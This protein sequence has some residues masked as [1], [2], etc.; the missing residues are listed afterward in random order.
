[1]SEKIPSNSGRRT[2]RLAWI[3]IGI[4]IL[5]IRMGFAAKFPPDM[6]WSDAAIYDSIAL[7]LLAGNGYSTDG[8]QPSRDRPPAYPFF[9]TLIY[10]VIGRN[11]YVVVFL[12]SLLA[13]LTAYLSA[14]L[15]EHVFDERAGWL[16]AL[17]VATYPALIYYDTRTLREGPTAFFV[18]LTVYLA[19]RAAAG[20]RRA[21]FFCGVCIAVSSMNRPETL[22]LI[23][24]ACLISLW[25]R[26]RQEILKLICLVLIPIFACWVPW[27]IRNKVTFGSWSPVRAG[28]VSTIWFGSRWAASGGDDQTPE[29]RAAIRSE[30]RTKIKGASDAEFETRFKDDLSQ[31]V[32]GRPLWFIQ[33]VGKKAVMFWKDANGVKKTLPRIHW[34]LPIAL[35]TYYYSLLLLALLACVVFRHRLPVRHLLITIVIYAGTYAILHVRNRYRVPLLPIVFILSSGGLVYLFDRFRDRLSAARNPA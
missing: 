12:Q 14:R 17:L 10:A 13:V 34:T 21:L 25:G 15:A 2:R 18:V 29:A 33:M 3:A 31:D 23:V 30:F 11:L 32:L 24:P 22:V 35:N 8:I 20:S 26:P 27:S 1:M 7:N 4:L 6:E 16:V 28:L 5:T 19:W 9:L